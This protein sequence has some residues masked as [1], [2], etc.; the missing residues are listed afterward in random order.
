MNAN[1]WPVCEKLTR[2]HPSFVFTR[3]VGICPCEQS[4]VEPSL[5]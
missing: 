5:V 3:V 4:R 2:V 1:S